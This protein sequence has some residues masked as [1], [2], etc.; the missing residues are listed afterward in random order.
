MCTLSGMSVYMYIYIYYVDLH[1]S[2]QGYNHN[3]ICMQLHNVKSSLRQVYK[4]K[5]IHVNVHLFLLVYMC[6]YTYVLA[7]CYLN[8]LDSRLAYITML[9]C[10]HRQDLSIVYTDL[11]IMYTNL[12]RDRG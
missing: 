6:V 8:L 9:T 7:Q 11:I 12:E 10:N 4:F 1:D 5:C 3:N 2:A